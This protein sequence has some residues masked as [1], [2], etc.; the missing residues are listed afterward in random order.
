MARVRMKPGRH[1]MALVPLL[2][3]GLGEAMSLSPKL[4]TKDEV[5]EEVRW[6]RLSLCKHPGELEVH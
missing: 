1:K 3:L 4:R 2:G 6:G 5:V